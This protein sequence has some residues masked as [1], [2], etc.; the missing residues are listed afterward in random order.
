MIVAGI[1]CR[2]NATATDIAA[3]I[4]AALERAAVPS[5]ALSAIATSVVKGSEPGIAAAAAQLRV[6]LVLVSQVDL[7]AADQ[8]SATQS[9]RVRTLSGVGS[10]AEA[11]A[12]AAG[13]RHARL[14]TPRLVS[15]SATCALAGSGDAQ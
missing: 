9:E 12:L 10:L 11:A 3:A 4:K 15:G 1:G 2:K 7:E 13:G 5:D 6:P 14:L 8:R